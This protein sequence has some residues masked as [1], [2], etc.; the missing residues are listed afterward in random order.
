MALTLAGCT[1]DEKNNVI[2]LDDKIS[3]QHPDY[4]L[5]DLTRVISD[6]WEKHIN[7]VVTDSIII[8]PSTSGLELPKVG[9]ILLK[10]EITDK[11]PYG[12][13]GKV[14]E[15]AQGENSVK[16]VTESI[17]L[18]EAFE[19]LTINLNSIDVSDNIS[20]V[21]KG[22]NN[23][24]SFVQTKASIGSH[25][26][27]IPFGVDLFKNKPFTVNVKGELK[28]NYIHNI[29]ESNTTYSEVSISCDD[30]ISI[31][32]EATLEGALRDSIF[33]PPYELKIQINPPASP[34]P[35]TLSMKFYIYMEVSGNISYSAKMERKTSTT[36]GFRY[37]KGFRN[38][39]TFNSKESSKEFEGKFSIDGKFSVGPGLEFRV[40]PFDKDYISA[41]VKAKALYAMDAKFECNTIKD[42]AWEKY[43]GTK[44]K[45]SLILSGA[46]GVSSKW[47]K[48]WNVSAEVGVE[49]EIPLVEAL[50]LPNITNLKI[51]DGSTNNEKQISYTSTDRTLFAGKYGTKLYDENN[52][53]IDEKYN[54][55]TPIEISSPVTVSPVTFNL[56]VGTNY[57][58]PFFELWGVKYV[59]Y[60]SK[61]ILDGVTNDGL[62]ITSPNYG[63]IYSC[64]DWIDIFVSGYTGIDWQ[65]Y[66]ELQYWCLTG[67]PQPNNAYEP[68]TYTNKAYPRKEAAYSF[69]FSPEDPSVWDGHWVKLV[70]INK[71]DNRRSAPQYARIVPPDISKIVGVWE[72]WYRSFSIFGGSQGGTV[73]LTINNDM[74]GVFDFVH[75]S[76]STGSYKVSVNYSNGYNVIGTEWID[77]PSGYWNMVN[78]EGGV[79]SN[80]IFS[81]KN[82]NIEF[83]LEKIE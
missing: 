33:I 28:K 45:Q 16:I 77:Y 10:T 4:V 78:L 25:E 43:K 81:G 50:L 71:K 57:A 17:T 47:G 83:E 64:G 76:G 61:M 14:T 30:G 38:L 7:E 79:I 41:F 75:E 68:S 46:V 80:G 54:I 56:P 73:T 37:E 65:D 27:T 35:L 69:T 52:K 31:N 82:F 11:F 19:E 60:K 39:E 48:L 58:C 62:T 53:E 3:E 49:S 1:K 2:P 74:T 40:K 66:L 15:V 42:D 70:A 5:G 51:T 63:T 24:A 36:C 23:S 8:L 6:E 29:R 55:D 12:F 13:L 67:E 59:D 20:A 26:I 32:L 72:G 9:E 34:I 22:E 18:E 21:I 44:G